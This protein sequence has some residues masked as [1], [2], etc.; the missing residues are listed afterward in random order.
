MMNSRRQATKADEPKPRNLAFAAWRLLIVPVILL[1]AVGSFI[2]P[3]I[4]RQSDRVLSDRSRSDAR[5]AP[6][7]R[8]RRVRP[9]TEED[10][11]ATIDPRKLEEIESLEEQCFRAVNRQREARG[12]KPFE[13]SENLLLV[14]RQ[15]SRWMAEEKFFSHTDPHGNTVKQRVEEAGI[16]WRMLGENLAYSNGYVNPVA[17]SMLGWM[18][19]PPHRRNILDP[20]FRD[21]AIGVWIGKD[22]TVYFTEIFLK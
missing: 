19:S 16:Q 17:M 5:S 2:L 7:D 8:A 20:N 10:I 18:D 14:A 11:K 1:L 12:L 22:G 13:F 9:Y 15:Y 21:T 3:A 6:D 4:A